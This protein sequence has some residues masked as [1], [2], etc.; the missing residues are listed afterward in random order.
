VR[1]HGL[2][3]RRVDR[4]R[5]SV[6]TETDVACVDQDFSRATVHLPTRVCEVGQAL[7]ARGLSVLDLEVDG[8]DSDRVEGDGAAKISRN[9]DGCS[10]GHTGLPKGNRVEG[11]LDLERVDARVGSGAVEDI[12]TRH[13]RAGVKRSPGGQGRV[14]NTV[15]V[16]AITLH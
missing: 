8:T 4:E 2:C 1:S 6:Q 15:D 9:S 11:A 14:I 7:R 3:I 13:R 16:E 12:Q 10:L 5:V